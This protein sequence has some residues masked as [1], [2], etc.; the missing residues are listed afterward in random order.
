MPDISF[1]NLQQLGNIGYSS[2]KMMLT[3]AY[4]RVGK[5]VKPLVQMFR[6]EGN[7]IKAFLRKI[8]TKWSEAD[9]DAVTIK[10]KVQVYIPEDQ[11]YEIDMRIKAN[12]G[13]PIE[14][15]R[16]SIQRYGKSVDAETTLK[17]I[18]EEEKNRNQATIGNVLE[19]AI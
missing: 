19:G 8:N 14:S 4:L 2:R 15:Q 5:E 6:R 13:Q 1:K 18:N 3:D 16:E 7:V 12:G 9:I 11:E 10:Y 17:E